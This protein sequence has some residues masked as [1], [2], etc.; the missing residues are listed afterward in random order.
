M[1]WSAKF[2]FVKLNRSEVKPDYSDGIGAFTLCDCL[3][4]WNAGVDKYHWDIADN[5]IL[6]DV[7][8]DF[9]FAIY[10]PDWGTIIPKYRF[11]FGISHRASYTLL[12]ENYALSIGDS[13]EG[14][15]DCSSGNENVFIHIIS[16]FSLRQR[17]G[18]FHHP[19]RMFANVFAGR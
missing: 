2:L 4:H 18:S 3:R 11:S 13:G 15:R 19:Y 10:E 6:K 1:H 14:Q 5:S 7:V 17:Y 16:P 12:R 9:S 8:S